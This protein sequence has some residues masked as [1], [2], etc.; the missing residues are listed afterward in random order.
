MKTTDGK[1]SQLTRFERYALL[2]VT[3]LLVGSLIEWLAPQSIFSIIQDIGLFLMIPVIGGYGIRL[4]RWIKGKL[5]FTVRNKILVSYIFIGGVPLALLMIGFFLA[6]I[7]IF[8]QISGVFLQNELDDINGTLEKINTHII[9]SDPGDGPLSGDFPR[10]FLT[11][12]QS[13]LQRV[14]GSLEEIRTRIYYDPAPSE[15]RPFLLAA[16][17]TGER[18]VKRGDVSAPVWLKSDYSGFTAE[19]G[20]LF[21]TDISRPSENLIL[22]TQIP[23]SD[24]VIIQIENKTYFDVELVPVNE[25]GLGEDFE[26]IYQRL[27]E[28]STLFSVLG[29]HFIRPIDWDTGSAVSARPILISV[30]MKVLFIQLFS[31][32]SR[33]I[34]ILLYVLGGIYLL[35]VLISIIA[36]AKI[37][38][39]I[40]RSINDIYR[41]SELVQKGEFD[42]RIQSGRNDQLEIMADSFNELSAGIRHLMGEVSRRERLEKE[43]EIAREVQAQLL[44]QEIPHSDC[45]QLAA[46]CLPAQRVGGDYY[47]FIQDTDSMDLVIGDIAGK[48]ISAALLM[49]STLATIHHTL[50]EKNHQNQVERMIAVAE[51][52]N[53]Q[54]F[55]KSSANAYSTLV[56]AS[57]DEKTRALTYCNAGHQPPLLISNGNVRE[58]QTGGTAIG[59]FAQWQFTADTI[60]LAP[61]D[62]IVFFTDGVVEATNQ[63]DDFYGNE[64]LLELVIENAALEPESLRR[65]ILESVMEWSGEGPQGDDITIIC[66]KVR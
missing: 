12:V 55:M 45:L 40:T 26:Y 29:V 18:I 64:R 60:I 31:Q 10:Q 44:P 37:A 27:S 34:M 21:L 48:G 39:G 35:T 65:K 32:S 66:L 62:L 24:K 58:L 63:D 15:G 28:Q 30:P 7:L 2:S 61:G 17:L 33:I 14:P 54:V 46:S 11:E 38:R 42:F 52:V 43:L 1:G 25:E 23:M 51:E 16:E 19:K 47:D 5:L 9:L 59:L 36:G 3:L 20:T 56:I 49:A 50:N 53:S 4:F 13:A 22:V 8:K 41:A 57:F 6:I